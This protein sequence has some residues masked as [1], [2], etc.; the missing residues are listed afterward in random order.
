MNVFIDW[1][2]T[3]HNLVVILTGLTFWFLAT[4]FIGVEPWDST[5]YVGFYLGV[6]GLSAICGWIYPKRP[7]RWGLILIFMQL[8]VMVA[9][10]VFNGLEDGLALVGLAYLTVQ[11]LPAMII[12]IAASH[13]KQSRRQK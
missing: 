5:G 11:T 8:P 10:S 2:K 7:W 1:R 12:A 6:L 4:A 13:L 3:I 9:H